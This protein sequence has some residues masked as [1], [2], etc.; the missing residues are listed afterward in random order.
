MGG[1]FAEQNE[2]GRLGISK[3]L[4]Q[5]GKPLLW[6]SASGERVFAVG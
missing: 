3:A 5:D 4:G 2:A 1:S 6:Q